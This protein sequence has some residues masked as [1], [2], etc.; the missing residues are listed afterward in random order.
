MSAEGIEFFR[1]LI[2]MLS[3]F[4]FAGIFGNG[5]IKIAHML[6]FNF[7]K[8]PE[9]NTNWIER[10]QEGEILHAENKFTNE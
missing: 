2:L 4:A 6:G 10:M 8:T 7:E 1:L 5:A 3:V 9:I